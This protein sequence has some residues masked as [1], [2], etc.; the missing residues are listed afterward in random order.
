MVS[1]ATGIASGKIFKVGKREYTPSIAYASNLGWELG[2]YL[3]LMTL[4]TTFQ[5]F[6]ILGA[7]FLLDLFS[8]SELYM[9]HLLRH[10]PRMLN[11]YQTNIEIYLREQSRDH[12]FGH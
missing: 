2:I 1:L 9:R 11:S 8:V 10:N 7:A 6:F 4:S 12:S 3:L 5:L